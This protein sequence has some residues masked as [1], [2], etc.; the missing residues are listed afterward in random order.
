[1]GDFGFKER[2]IRM[3]SNIMGRANGKNKKIM[4]LCTISILL[5]ITS[6]SKKETGRKEDLIS[7]V[8]E[9]NQL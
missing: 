2:R 9:R 5:S 6:C 4:L 1:M 3:G 7:S 8:E